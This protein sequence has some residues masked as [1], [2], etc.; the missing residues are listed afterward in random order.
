M[1]EHGAVAEVAVVGVKDEAWGERVVACVVPRAGRDEECAY[2]KL[3]SFAKERL[4]PYKVPKEVVLMHELPRNAVGKVVKPRSPQAARRPK[5]TQSPRIAARSSS[6]LATR[7]STRWTAWP[8]RSMTM[9]TGTAVT[10]PNGPPPP[11]VCAS[12]MATGNGTA[13]VFR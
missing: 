13:K 8:S 6:L 9:V 10:S 4:A 7:P 5:M 3:R 1:R 11:R 12:A 2:D